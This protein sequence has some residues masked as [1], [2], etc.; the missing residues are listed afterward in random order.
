MI[1][2]LLNCLYD[3]RNDDMIL[4]NVLLWPHLQVRSNVVATDEIQ[5]I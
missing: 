5:E 2:G 3:A 4:T 1:D